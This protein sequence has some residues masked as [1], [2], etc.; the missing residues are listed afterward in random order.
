MQYTLLLL[1]SIHSLHERSDPAVLQES[2]KMLLALKGSFLLPLTLNAQQQHGFNNCGRRST[3]LAGRCSPL[4]L[5][6]VSRTSDI[7]TTKS[8]LKKQMTV[9]SSCAQN[10]PISRTHSRVVRIV[11]IPPIQTVMPEDNQQLQQPTVAELQAIAVNEESVLFVDFICRHSTRLIV[12]GDS[13]RLMMGVRKDIPNDH[14]LIVCKTL[15]QYVVKEKYA[16]EEFHRQSMCLFYLLSLIC[17]CNK[18]HNVAPMLLSQS[19]S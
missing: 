5:F 13:E 8:V 10:S 19:P 6:S 16:G 11:L 9:S 7:R 12:Q 17:R 15:K 4:V 1:S 14:Y 18:H 3:S 2:G